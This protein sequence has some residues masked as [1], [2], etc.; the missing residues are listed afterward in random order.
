VFPPNLFIV[1][2]PR[3]GTTSLYHYLG[4][5]PNIYMSRVKEPRFW[6]Q[7]LRTE[8]RAFHG[9]LYR[10]HLRSLRG[11]VTLPG[12]LWARRG[13]RPQDL[14]GI[15]SHSRY[16]ELFDAANSSVHRYRG[17]ASPDSMWSRTAASRIAE[18]SPD[19][20]IIIMLREPISYIQSIHREALRGRVGETVRSLD[21][22]LSLEERRRQ[23]LAVPCTVRYPYSVLYRLQAHFDEQVDRFLACFGRRRIHFVLLD[24]LADDARAVVHE[25]LEFLDLP[26]PAGPLDLS[27][28]GVRSSPFVP[29]SDAWRR[30]LTAEF[31]PVVHRLQQQ[32]GKPVA[33]RWGYR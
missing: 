14:L 25:V 23:G 13:L 18:A 33:D 30:R 32:I 31:R 6:S 7:D 10:R 28:K 8:G 29:L 21:R 17:E 15:E 20:R 24:D 3:C 11:L 4:Q 27:P 16:L 22:A 12:C 26:V 1:G 19:A 5:H 2:A 9:G